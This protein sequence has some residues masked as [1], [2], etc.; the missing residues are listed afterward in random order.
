MGHEMNG[1]RDDF[2]SAESGMEVVFVFIFK[3]REAIYG[4]LNNDAVTQREP[5]RSGRIG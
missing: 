2:Y 5:A 4:I 1:A 3:H